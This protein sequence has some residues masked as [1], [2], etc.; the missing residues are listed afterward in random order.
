MKRLSRYFALCITAVTCTSLLADITVYKQETKSGRRSYEK[1]YGI[2]S[3][4]RAEA[5]LQTT[6]PEKGYKRCGVDPTDGS[7]YP[8]TGHYKTIDGPS[9]AIFDHPESG[10]SLRL[11]IPGRMR[12]VTTLRVG[13]RSFDYKSDHFSNVP[14][15]EARAFVPLFISESRATWEL[16]GKS[17][18]ISLVGFT[19]AWNYCTTF[20][21]F[22][23]LKT[24]DQ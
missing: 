20:V 4:W 10:R 13:P 16:E 23:P 18:S 9:F 5:T 12:K 19:D 15:D 3:F 6:G 14:E 22:D 7:R 8:R 24:T 21:G 2:S 17:M 1:T 11:G